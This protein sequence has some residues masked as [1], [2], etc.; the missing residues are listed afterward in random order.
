MSDPTPSF[1]TAARRQYQVGQLAWDNWTPDAYRHCR[2]CGT[3]D[4]GR[5]M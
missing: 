4:N 3:S 1:W 2:H 5:R